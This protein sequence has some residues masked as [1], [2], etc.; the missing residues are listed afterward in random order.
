[1]KR[2]NLLNLVLIFSVIASLVIFTKAV[3]ED[4]ASSYDSLYYACDCFKYDE[5]FAGILSYPGV[6][7]GYFGTSVSPKSIIA[8]LERQEKSPPLKP[9]FS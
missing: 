5:L 6:F 8:Y 1:M 9:H 2:L 7:Y 3:C 4:D